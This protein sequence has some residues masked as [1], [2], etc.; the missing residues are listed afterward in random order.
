MSVNYTG[1][2]A[3]VEA[4]SPAPGTNVAPVV[5]LPADGDP[6][7]AASVAQALKVPADFLAFLAA[8]PTFGPW[9]YSLTDATIAADTDLIAGHAFY[10][11]L[12][13]NAARTLTMVH[14]GIIYVSGIL[15]IVNTGKIVFGKKA[16]FLNGNNAGAGTRGV[17]GV[18][19]NGDSFG[20]IL[21][22]A[23]GGGGGDSG[24]LI[25]AAG[26][27]V[28][29]GAALLGGG[30]SALGGAGGGG[31][32]GAH[33]AGAAGPLNS[34]FAG[35][36]STIAQTLLQAILQAGWGFGRGGADGART[37]LP[38]G[39]E[40][41]S[42]GGGGGGTATNTGT[43]GG[44]GG[45]GGGLGLVIARGVVIASDG[46]IQAPGGDGGNGFAAGEAAGGGGA[47][48]GG[49]VGLVY[50]G[51]SGPALTAANCCPAGTPGT[52]A[53]GGAAGAAGAVG[54]VQEFVVGI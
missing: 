42:G 19:W 14:P 22:G 13:I 37:A 10:R 28:G 53:N 44:G 49:F 50:A 11:N 5:V 26:D 17:G 34:W 41:G 35:T 15:T 20:Q 12:T 38:F 27:S 7:S 32:A 3:A 8:M 51:K 24:H 31:G 23:N 39:L 47:G 43:A 33:A 52:G 54:N 45:A 16:G 2:P 9:G 18:G 6:A 29:A 30:G 40:G 25:P 46:C 48:G 21:G 1:N 4:P 36:T